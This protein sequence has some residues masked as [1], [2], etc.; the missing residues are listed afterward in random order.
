[1]R[2]STGVTNFGRMLHRN[3]Q[4]EV[5]S[6]GPVTVPWHDARSAPEDRQRHDGRV[7]TCSEEILACPPA[8][9]P[10]APPVTRRVTRRRRP[11]GQDR[12]QRV[13]GVSGALTSMTLAL[14]FSSAMRIA[15]L[16]AA[17]SPPP[18]TTVRVP[19]V[20]LTRLAL[21]TVTADTSR[22]SSSG[23][24]C[25][26]ERAARSAS[27]LVPADPVAGTTRPPFGAAG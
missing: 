26:T 21:V 3:P 6:N 8:S 24:A 5:D 14:V 17:S 9:D 22:L 4:R 23:R 18:Q 20:N 2:P 12:P 25:T 11:E 7:A 16:R 10:P 1:M 19:S 27:R 13:T 15:T